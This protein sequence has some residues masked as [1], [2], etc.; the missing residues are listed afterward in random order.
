MG[1]DTRPF[2]FPCRLDFLRSGSYE[3]RGVIRH[4]GDTPED[5]HYVATCYLGRGKYGTFDDETF[6]G[7]LSWSEL[8]D[9]VDIQSEAYVLLYERVSGE[10][11]TWR[12]EVATTPFVRGAASQDVVLANVELE[13]EPVGEG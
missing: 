6:G 9:N 7:F 3:L 5:G 4:A 11:R 13:R 12:E 2:Q 1:K 8:S 10:R